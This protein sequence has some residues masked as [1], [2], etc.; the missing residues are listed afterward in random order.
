MASTEEGS[1]SELFWAFGD[2]ESEG[3][4]ERG[5]EIDEDEDDSA[6]GRPNTV[7]RCFSNGARYCSW[8]FGLEALKLRPS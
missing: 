7:L 8:K 5:C 4:G 2:A 6:E 1:S 3:A